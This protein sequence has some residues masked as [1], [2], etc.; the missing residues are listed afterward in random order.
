MK[1]TILLFAIFLSMGIFAQ[2]CGFDQVQKELEN[3][4]PQIKKDMYTGT[5]YEIPIIVH[6]ITSSDPS[7]ASLSL[8]DAQIQTWIDNCNKMF[9]TNFGAP[10]F[11]EGS[12]SL[13]GDVLP[14]K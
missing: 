6:V 14:Y 2:T 1:K 4:F 7:N 10:F 5:I 8:S 9:A 11:P 12:G 3:Q 13:D